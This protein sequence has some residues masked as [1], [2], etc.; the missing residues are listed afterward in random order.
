M[1][2]AYILHTTDMAGG[3]TKSFLA[4]LDCLLARG[5]EAMVV[6]PGRDGVCAELEKRHIGVWIL[7]YRMA[8]YP[9]LRQKRDY[10]Y[11]IPRLLLM[12]FQNF[13]ASRKLLRILK[14]ER[15]DIVH[16]N[17]SVT[18]IAYKAVAS[19]HIPHV[20]HFRE[21]GE[22]DFGMRYFPSKRGC[23]RRLLA[24]KSVPVAITHDIFGHHNL[25]RYAGSRV[26][27]NGV[28]A[29]SD[30]F[31]WH[32]KERYFLYAGRVEQGKGV[33]EMVKAYSVYA[34]GAASEAYPLLIAGDDGLRPAYT[35]AI[36]E[37]ARSCGLADKVRFLGVR[38][39]V[40]QL[41]ERAVAVVIPSLSEGFGRTMA[42]AMLAGSLCI[43]RDSG[44][45]REQFDNGRRLMGKEIGLRFSSDDELPG[46]LSLVASTPQEQFRDTIEAAWR[47]V[48][49]LYTTE[50]NAEAVFALY[51]EMLNGGD[52]QPS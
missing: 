19:L 39:D 34:D 22:A 6:A 52:T 50:S 11:F 43:G 46:L 44:G 24:T 42:E 20:V 31:S 37:Y 27:Y 40:R 36:K 49:A 32:D 8:I 9:Y 28:C 51:Q 16:T 7:T 48:N 14:S 47:T 21:Y 4:L 1:K 18:D 29:R 17:V 38:S 25:R 45:T 13:R 35:A 10:L 15:P 2:I 12:A 3:A 41:M 26:I 33:M 30:V 5:V 23:G